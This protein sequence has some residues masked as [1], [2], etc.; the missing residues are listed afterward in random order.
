[1]LFL[2]ALTWEMIGKIAALAAIVIVTRPAYLLADHHAKRAIE[3][4]TKDW[5][6]GH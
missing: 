3:E 6:R 1:M 5:R 2:D 4:D